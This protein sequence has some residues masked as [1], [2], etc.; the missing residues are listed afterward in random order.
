MAAGGTSAAFLFAG[1]VY[2]RA[3][4]HSI[5]A[6]VAMPNKPM[7][8]PDNP[9]WTVEDFKRARPPHEVLPPHILK[10][11][12]KTSGPQ[13]PIAGNESVTYIGTVVYGRHS[14]AR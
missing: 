13:A 7:S 3:P 8:D 1:L 11:F 12:P 4:K 9:E 2:N 5:Q 6:G 10:A 14:H